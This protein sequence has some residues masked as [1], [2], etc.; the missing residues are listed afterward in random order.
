MYLLNN[1]NTITDCILY[2]TVS[3]SQRKKSN[4]NIV[5]IIQPIGTH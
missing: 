1:S 2:R 4:S 3:L 5:A